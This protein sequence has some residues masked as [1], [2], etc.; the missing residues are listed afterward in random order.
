MKNKDIDPEKKKHGI[1]FD[2]IVTNLCTTIIILL[3][4]LGVYEITENV[5]IKGMVVA[6]SQKSIKGEN[7]YAEGIPTTVDYLVPLRLENSHKEV[8]HD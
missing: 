2:I 8:N 6:A 1:V 3:I 4:Y 5:R 7:Y